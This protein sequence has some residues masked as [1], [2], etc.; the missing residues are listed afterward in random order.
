MY[1]LD[2][3]C[4]QFLIIS[5]SFLSTYR[6]SYRV[7]YTRAPDKHETVKMRAR[8]RRIA[9]RKCPR[10][11]EMR[12]GALQKYLIFALKSTEP[13]CRMK[14]AKVWVYVPESEQ[15]MNRTRMHVS[16]SRVVGNCIARA[17]L[18]ASRNPG[19]LIMLCI[20]M[21]YMYAA[22]SRCEFFSLDFSFVHCFCWSSIYQRRQNRF[23]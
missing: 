5:L 14:L 19:H 10:L 6:H 7:M 4:V 1:L 16:A 20:Y 15:K 22:A 11:A 9:A 3:H 23:I 8:R 12:G 18:P 21:L 2:R 13:S 17:R